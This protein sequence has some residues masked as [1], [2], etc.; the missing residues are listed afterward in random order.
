MPRTRIAKSSRPADLRA[1]LLCTVATIAGAQP[2]PSAPAQ[3]ADA[4]AQ[5]R[6]EFRL[7]YARAATPA[8]AAD[9]DA[10]EAYPLYPYLERARLVAALTAARGAVGEVDEAARAFLERHAYEPLAREARNAWLRSLARRKQ[11]A[12]FAAQFRGSADPSLRCEMLNARIALD[13]TA[14]LAEAI[15]GEWLTGSQL[16]PECE[17]PFQWL[18]ARAALTPELVERRVRLL[19]ENGQASFARVIARPLP[20]ERAAPL[21]A[22]ADLLERPA[23]ALDALASQESPP[24]ETEALIAGWTRLARNDPG[25]ALARFDGFA[26]SVSGA[27]IRSRIALAL[28]LG[29]AWDRRAEALDLF[30]RVPLADLDD[31]A[32][33]WRARAALWARDWRTAASAIDGMSQAQRALP[34]WR[35]WAA[36]AAA[37]QGDG[38]RARGLYES[39]LASDN[40]YAAV[41]AARL[42]RPAEPHPEPLPSDADALRALEAR[43]GLVR[44]HELLRCGLPLAAAAEWSS[45][46]AALEE[47]ERLQAI[48]LAA[49]W[50]WHDISVQTATR[51]RV[52]FDYELLYPQ[53]YEREVRAAAQVANLATPLIYGVIR[54]E[55]LFRA[56]A[57]STAGALGL[58]QLTPDTARIVAR[59]IAHPVPRAADL[60]DPELNLRLG[61]SYLRLLIDRYG[62]NLP[63]ALAGYNAGPRAAA[64]WLPA[65]PLD[66]D[67]WIENIP[68]NETREY[69]QRVLWHSVVFGWLTTGA[70]QSTS[71]W[72]EP[73]GPLAD[74]L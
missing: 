68:F 42:G 49:R 3:H 74:E 65:Q 29:L 63:V 44:A 19:L 43:P 28:A 39:V 2:G 51:H 54:Q 17:A 25:A 24:V 4:Y 72:L 34:R 52:F 23:A 14:G 31:N 58:A 8:P 1:A 47:P 21:I 60:F 16:P 48:H 70:P 32:L 15:V 66:A 20:A 62:G 7:A 45:V 9:S 64:R 67:I 41:A 35:Y 40:Y 46:Y 27:A 38:D 57:V 37:A 69:V 61:A 26:A 71:S 11:W 18:R 5:V 30:A 36:R 6:E 33:A 12:A 22:W 56:D 13:D 50:G 59:Q 73:V 53:P 10:L 55:S